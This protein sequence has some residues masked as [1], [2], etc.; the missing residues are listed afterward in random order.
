MMVVD[1]AEVLEEKIDEKSSL[2]EIVDAF[3]EVCEYPVDSKQDLKSLETGLFWDYV[4][5]P[6]SEFDPEEED[7]SMEEYENYFFDLVR[8]FDTPEDG[9]EY[10]QLRV[11]VVY[12]AEDVEDPAMEIIWED[13]IEEDFF[14]Y[15]RESDIYKELKDV[16]IYRVDIEQSE[17]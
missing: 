5:H 2:E 8:Q 7:F 11:S 14:D 3:E 1:M 9:D 16:P 17:T 4:E 15:I 10:T 12:R 6:F 13:M